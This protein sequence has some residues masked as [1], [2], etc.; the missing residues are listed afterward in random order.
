MNV[1]SPSLLLSHDQGF[2]VPRW[3]AGRCLPRSCFFPMSFFTSTDD[4]KI[5]PFPER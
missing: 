1:G 5:D 3:T 2:P 4:R